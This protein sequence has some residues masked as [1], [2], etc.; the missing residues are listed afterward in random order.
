MNPELQLTRRSLMMRN[1]L[2]KMRK[3]TVIG[4]LG[5]IV[6]VGAL[7]TLAGQLLVTA[8]VAVLAAAQYFTTINQPFA[9]APK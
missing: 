7:G 9:P 2:V 1:K 3:F 4:C 8:P 5:G 6:A